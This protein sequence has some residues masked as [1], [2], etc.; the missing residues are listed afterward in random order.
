MIAKH[1]NKA[2]MVNAR[3]ELH[4]KFPH[5]REETVEQPA[6]DQ[7]MVWRIDDAQP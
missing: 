4:A 1:R 6:Q 5:F 7:I 3:C 2:L